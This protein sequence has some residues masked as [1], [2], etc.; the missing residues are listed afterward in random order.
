MTTIS[1]TP[2]PFTRTRFTWLAYAVMFCFAVGVALPGPVV[3]FIGERLGL[4][5]TE[6]GLHFTVLAAGNLAVG[7]LGDRLIDR[8][9]SRA[10]TWASIVLWVLGGAGL[11]YGPALWATL[12]GVAVLGIGAGACAL[13]A[14]AT[15][16]D[17]HPHYQTQAITEGNIAAGL[18]VAITPLTVGL[19]ERVGFGWSSI[20]LVLALV[21]LGLVLAF[22]NV[23]FPQPRSQ[24]DAAQSSGSG[25]RPLPPL[26]WMFG[27]VVFMTI[28]IEWVI[29]SWAPDFLATVRGFD[30]GTAASLAS[31][32]AW[33]VV[34]GRVLGRWLLE[35]IPEERVLVGAYALILVVFPVYA[36][37]P[38][39]AVSLGALVVLGLVLANQFPLALSA[40]MDAGGDQTGRASARVSVFGGLATLTLPQTVGS[41]ADRVGIQ[42]AYGLVM[43]LAAVAVAVALFALRRRAA[44]HALT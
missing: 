12:T 21:S 34:L 5:Y 17:A 23:P 25:E 29:I 1:T 26:Y 36:Y 42:N 39:P 16:A 7:L 35:R 18:G 10:A 4:N 3:P 32:F 11:I 28:A 30:Q 6:R 20:V 9:G 2:N 15:L 14:T 24:S 22:W 27:A 33:A 38:T 19:L 41:L 40:A 43:V 44:Q 8:I 37:A 31:G 13:I